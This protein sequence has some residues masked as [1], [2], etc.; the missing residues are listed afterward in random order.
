M[1]LALA[2]AVAALRGRNN[3]SSNSSNS[4][5]NSRIF[6]Y[7]RC[8]IKKYEY[9]CEYEYE[10]EHECECFWLSLATK[11]EF[12]IKVKAK[13]KAKA[14]ATPTANRLQ[15]ADSRQRGHLTGDW[16]RG[17]RR[18]SSQF[19]HI[20]AECAKLH[21]HHMHFACSVSFLITPP[22]CGTNSN[23]RVACVGD[24]V[25]LINKTKK[26]FIFIKKKRQ[27]EQKLRCGFLSNR[28]AD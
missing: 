14:N 10:Y 25:S 24:A 1:R 16:E 20:S 12:L 7:I 17:D 6:N 15:R 22:K 26:Y 3:S 28:R 11:R 21:F 9:E 23:K 13:A 27:K 18:T 19:C 8:E 4:D 2:A 5:N